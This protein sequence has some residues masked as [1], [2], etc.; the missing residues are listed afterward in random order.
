MHWVQCVSA[1]SEV[2]CGHLSRRLCSTKSTPFTTSMCVWLDPA[3]TDYNWTKQSSLDRAVYTDRRTQRQMCDA[4]TYFRRNGH[5]RHR[6]KD[7][8]EHWWWWRRPRV[9]VEGRHAA[10]RAVL[11]APVEYICP[12]R[13]LQAATIA[14]VSCRDQDACGPESP[15]V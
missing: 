11:S 10:S 13:L 4:R 9:N 8:V 6:E 1:P 2:T 3:T 5:I 12:R 14:M 15:R 7:N